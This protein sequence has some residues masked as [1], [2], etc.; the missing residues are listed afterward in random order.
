MCCQKTLYSV[1]VKAF[2]DVFMNCVWSGGFRCISR[3]RKH[4]DSVR[5]VG[6]DKFFRLVRNKNCSRLPLREVYCYRLNI[7]VKD[8]LRSQLTEF[9]HVQTSFKLLILFNFLQKQRLNMKFQ[10]TEEYKI[11]QKVWLIHYFYLLLAP[12][13]VLCN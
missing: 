2:F 10:L 4:N 6:N 5:K 9:Q 12:L 1:K 3:S 13:P 8:N 7:Y 11:W